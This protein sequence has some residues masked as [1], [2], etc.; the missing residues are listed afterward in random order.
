V[1]RYYGYRR[2][3]GLDE[4]IERVRRAA[5][6]GDPEAQEEYERL[7]A[8]A[9][10]TPRTNRSHSLAELA[11]QDAGGA[12][13]IEFVRSAVRSL[14][15]SDRMGTVGALYDFDHDPAWGNREFNQW[16]KTLFELPMI[17]LHTISDVELVIPT[18]LDSDWGRHYLSGRG[19]SRANVFN[20]ANSFEGVIQQADLLIQIASSE[21]EPYQEIPPHYYVS[22]GPYDLLVWAALIMAN[23][24][25][26]VSIEE[27][28]EDRFDEDFDPLDV[29]VEYFDPNHECGVCGGVHFPPCF[30]G[31]SIGLSVN[32]VMEVMERL[33]LAWLGESRGSV[34]P[35]ALPPKRR[36]ITSMT[37]AECPMCARLEKYKKKCKK[38]A[39]SNNPLRRRRRKRRNPERGDRRL[40]ELERA[41]A[42]G[43]PDAIERLTRLTTQFAPVFDQLPAALREKALQNLI[44]VRKGMIPEP[45]LAIREYLA[46]GSFRMGMAAMERRG[47]WGSHPIPRA[48]DLVLETLRF[49]FPN[50]YAGSSHYD[51]LRPLP[52]MA[53]DL[54]QVRPDEHQ[55]TLGVFRIEDPVT[56]S[57]YMPE[58]SGDRVEID[59]PIPL[60][61]LELEWLDEIRVQRK[62]RDGLLET[63]EIV[64]EAPA[65]GMRQAWKEGH[66][67]G[68]SLF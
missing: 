29:D 40:R 63:L 58:P 37:P 62:S 24:I 3:A 43:D 59:M 33:L 27:F 55:V 39:Y 38:H 12:R 19:L 22:I 26:E 60:P 45:D 14:Q 15:S 8:A 44:D 1:R 32:Q 49:V 35:G 20:M 31:T 10:R 50:G 34:G 68:D 16:C 46:P 21:D 41:A 66:D 28:E 65:G 6:L 54:S 11:G 53:P 17:E 42:A 56:R 5:A 23:K 13:L 18:I 57:V 64:A 47:A 25:D 48:G 4:R 7:L 9:G 36:E 51:S 61:W 52:G 2:N 67:L 30:G